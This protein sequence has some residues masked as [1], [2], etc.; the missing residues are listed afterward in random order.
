MTVVTA[1]V[2][3]ETKTKQNNMILPILA[4]LG[5][6]IHIGLAALGSA[7]GVGLVGMGASTAVGRNPGAANQILVQS[8]L[9]I[10]LAEAVVFYAIYLAPH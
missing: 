4:E 6:S 8:L 1:E 3:D 10:A 2:A 7:I 9:G 5:G